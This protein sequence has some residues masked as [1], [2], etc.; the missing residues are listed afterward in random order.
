M[1]RE[2]DLRRHLEGLERL[3]DAVSAMKSIAAHHLRQAR[4]EVEPLRTYRRGVEATVAMA[5]VGLPTA[6][7]GAVGL[8]VVG[9]ELGMCGGYNAR[10]GEVAVAARRADGEGP[11]LAVG[12]RVATWLRRRGVEPRKAYP[13]PTGIAAMPT[14]LLE[15]SEDILRLYAGESLARVELVSP[16]FQGVGEFEPR[17]TTLLPVALPEPPAEAAHGRLAYATG[18]HATEAAER[19]LL[20]VSLYASVIEAMAS[21]QGAR[22]VATQAAESWLRSRTDRLRRRLA[23]EKREAS[24]REAIEVAGSVRALRPS[25]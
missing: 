7:E 24:T 22:T 16:L 6:R 10:I 1:K 12:H 3:L 8:V 15:L 4:R 25:S 23:A 21:E 20:Y 19:E 14:L 13:M 9:S 2:A 18:A 11:T 17:A 5:G